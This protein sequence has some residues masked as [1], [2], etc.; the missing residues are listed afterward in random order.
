MKVSLN[1]ANTKVHFVARN[2][3]GNEIH[4]DGAPKV[5]GEGAG[6][7][8]METLLAAL[9]G[10][11]SMDVVEILRKQ[12]AG[13]EDLKIDVHGQRPDTTP[14]PFSAIHLH[15]TVVGPVDEAKASRALDLA[16]NKYCSVGEMLKQSAEISYSY[17]IV[18][19]A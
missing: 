10:C 6:F 13:L 16:V 4:I 8:P 3:D 2:E 9:A 1:R 14:S 7:R 12:R 15:F 11:A 19:G 18:S 5:G 17:E